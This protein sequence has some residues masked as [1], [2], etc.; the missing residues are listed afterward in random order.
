MTGSTDWEQ[1]GKQERAAGEAEYKAAQTQGY[2]EGTTDRVRG[3]KDSV[4]GSVTG[5]K[6]QETQGECPSQFCL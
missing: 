5:D 2:V 1:A 3:A 6:V 4:V